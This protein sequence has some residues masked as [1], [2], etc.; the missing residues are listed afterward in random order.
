LDIVEVAPPLDCA[1]VTSF[2]A[3]KVIYEVLGW[4][5]TGEALDCG[6]AR[7]MEEQKE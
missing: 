6:P 3:I 4:M 2:V 5:K 1:D 7:A